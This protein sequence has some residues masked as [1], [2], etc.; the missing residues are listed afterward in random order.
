MNS[1]IDTAANTSQRESKGVV[2]PSD[3]QLYQKVSFVLIFKVIFILL[4]WWVCFSHP[5]AKYLNNTRLA[6]HLF[7]N[8]TQGQ[9][10]DTQR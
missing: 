8:P 2:I 7:T 10:H 6:Q 3:R 5:P 9:T 1:T 4:L